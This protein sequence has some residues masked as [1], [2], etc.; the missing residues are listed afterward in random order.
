M[1]WAYIA[2][3]IAVLLFVIVVWQKLENAFKRDK[4]DKSA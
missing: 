3:G 4:K 2:G 1:E